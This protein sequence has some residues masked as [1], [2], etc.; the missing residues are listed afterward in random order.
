MSWLQLEIKHWLFKTVKNS[1]VKHILLET[2]QSS[3]RLPNPH[4]SSNVAFL[5]LWSFL[6]SMCKCLRFDP[7]IFLIPFTQ[8]HNHAVDIQWKRRS[9]V[10]LSPNVMTINIMS[11][12]ERSCYEFLKKITIKFDSRRSWILDDSGIHPIASIPDPHL[13]G[14]DLKWSLFNSWKATRTQRSP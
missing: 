6:L 14:L 3:M 5:T 1:H 4:Y 10:T 8:G 9:P 12:N 7:K 13:K 11:I 2:V